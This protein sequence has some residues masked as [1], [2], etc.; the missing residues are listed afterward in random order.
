MEVAARVPVDINEFSWGDYEASRHT[1]EEKSAC[2]MIR[3][4]QRQNTDIAI[5]ALRDRHARNVPLTL[6]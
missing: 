2:A 4:F 3:H 5:V 6:D 1:S